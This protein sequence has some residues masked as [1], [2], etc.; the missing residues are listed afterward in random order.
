VSGPEP[1]HCTR[2]RVL[3][4]IPSVVL[5]ALVGSAPRGDAAEAGMPPLFDD[6]ERRMF[7]LFWQTANARNGLVPDRWPSATFA[8]IAAVGF[9]LTS[10]PIGA[11]RGHISR[12]A[13]RE[14]TLA[15]LRFFASAP[16][17]GAARGMSGHHGFFYRFLEMETGE[18]AGDVELSTIDTALLLAGMLFAQ[19]WF[20]ANDAKEVEI[21]RLVDDVHARVDWRW[22]QPR[23]PVICHGWT[24]EE[25][26]LPYDWRGYNE[27]ML[28]YL[29]ALGSPTHA[30]GPEA[31]HAWTLG[32]HSS[33]GRYME[34]EH[35]GFAPLF[36]HQYSHVWI[37][38]RG[39]QDVFM[40]DRG[41]DFFENSRRATLAQRAYAIANPQGWRDYGP[42]VWGLTACDGPGTM[43]ANDVA[44]RV[45]RFKGYAARGAGLKGGFDDGT[46]APTAS[47]ASLPFAPDIVTAAVATMHERFGSVVYGKYGFLDA[48][49]RSLHAAPERLAHGRIEPGFG[50]VDTDYIA[51]NTG[52]AL[53]MLA[54]Q[55]SGMVWQRMRGH[56]AVHRGLERA[57]FQGGWLV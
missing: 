33:W 57:G 10:Y 34:Q 2:R 36:G 6:L 27:A 47:L 49:N 4:W 26:F 12:E 48:F 56:P 17:G 54:N 21:R 50:W 37:D 9:A 31:W 15:T 40:R 1:G 23:A 11:E 43:T 30:V 25:G 39:I 18:R 41:I 7:D 51:I 42:D 32:N 16:Q 55:R 8:S 19:A 53:A 35:V 52:P 22:A 3:E 45:R 28:V 46:I 14:R 24:P 38:F 29:L 20:D 44:G 13:A 5:G